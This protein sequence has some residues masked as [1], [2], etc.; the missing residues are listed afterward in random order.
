MACYGAPAR[1]DSSFERERAF[2]RVYAEGRWLHGIDGAL[3]GSGWSDVTAG[4]GEKAMYAVVDVV[5][6]M[7][8]RSIV[9][10]PVG[11]GCF[12][13]ALLSVLRNQSATQTLE[14]V[15]MDIVLK[16]IDSNRARYGNKY[17][18]FVHTDILAA[19]ARLPPADLIFSRQMLQHLCNQDVLRFID[20]V[21]RSSARFAMLTT[22][23]TDESFAN[24]DIGC[25]SGGFRPQDLTKPPFNLPDPIMLFSENYP[26]DMR[27]GLGLWS[28]R[29]LRHRLIG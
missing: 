14:Y 22:F 1:V 10:I 13:G 6:S 11:D 27:V 23:H 4:Q 28:I 16:L 7:E 12:S 15:G 5:S 18:Q 25:H 20:L 19:N 24:T 3:C 17:T 29:T 26:T 21:A 8:I 9:D 2:E